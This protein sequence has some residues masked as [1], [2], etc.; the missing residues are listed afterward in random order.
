MEKT[1]IRFVKHSVGRPFTFFQHAGQLQLDFSIRQP[2]AH[3]P[4]LKFTD[5]TEMC[6]L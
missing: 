3:L 4:M 1:W 2:W 5:C 6:T